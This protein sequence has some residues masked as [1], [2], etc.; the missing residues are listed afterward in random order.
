VVL[1]VDALVSPAATPGSIVNDTA[2]FETDLDGNGVDEVFIGSNTVSLLVAPAA[3]LAISKFAQTAQPPLPD[4]QNSVLA[5]GNSVFDD[6]LGQCWQRRACNI[7][8]V[9]TVSN[10]GPSN[11][12]NVIIEDQIPGGPVQLA[13][14]NA[15]RR[16]ILSLD[17]YLDSQL[18]QRLRLWWPSQSLMTRVARQSVRRR[19][20]PSAVMI[21]ARV[22]C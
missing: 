4:P 7:S 19:R 6:Q 22:R 10:L 8:Y 21:S 18:F 14:V 5:G 17:R 16:I 15:P 12:T 13:G 2:F 1:K 20:L 3:D 9:L 11:A